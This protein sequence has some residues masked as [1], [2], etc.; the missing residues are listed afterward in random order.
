LVGP[1]LRHQV[2]W[3]MV[4]GGAVGEGAGGVQGAE[5]ASLGVVGETSGTAEIECAWCVQRNAVVDDVPPRP[6]L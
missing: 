2:M 6:C 3:R 5:C 4:S 1:P